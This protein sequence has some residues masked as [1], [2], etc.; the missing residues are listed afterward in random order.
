MKLLFYSLITLA[1]IFEGLGDV[2]LKKWSVSGNK[3]IFFVLGLVI[4][5]I[6]TVVWAFSLK[7]EF[8]SKSISIVTVLNTLFVVAV[9]VFYFKESLSWVNMLGIALA[10]VAII[11]IER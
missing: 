10:I 9:G 3:H 5:L 11:L 8:L 2:L 6:A 7:H 4:Y 1:A